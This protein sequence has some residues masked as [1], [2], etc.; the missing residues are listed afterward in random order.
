MFK[1]L[2]IATALLLTTVSCN[3]SI[4]GQASSE[5]NPPSANQGEPSYLFV[6]KS[7]YGVIQQTRSGT[8]QLILNHGDMENVLVFSDRPYR[9]VR[10]IMGSALQS[11][12]TEGNNSFADDPPNAAV[13]IKQQVQT[14]IVMNMNIQGDQTIFTIQS[15]GPNSLTPM[16]G[17]CEVFFDGGNSGCDVLNLIDGCHGAGAGSPF[18]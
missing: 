1:N 6:I 10:N 7:N 9:L 3:H 5:Q 4:L 13:M 2:L 8:Y 16:S 15:D 12:W 18:P 11:V 14:V 17:V